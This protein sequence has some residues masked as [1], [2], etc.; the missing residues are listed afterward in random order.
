VATWL[1][2]KGATLRLGLTTFPAG[3]VCEP[4]LAPTVA[5]PA[6]TAN[7]VGTST[8]LQNNASQITL[9]LQA[10][11]PVGGTPTGAA[12]T[13]MSTLTGLTSNDGRADYVV[14]LTDG[15]PNCNANNANSL[16]ACGA[17]CTPAQTSACQCTASICS[18]ALCS[19]GCLDR[20]ATV[21]AVSALAAA[22]VKTI[23]VGFGAD[24]LTTAATPVLDGMARAGGAPRSCPNG[25]DAEC[26]G[27][28][29]VS[30]T[31]APAFYSA[32]NGA[33]LQV[34]LNGLF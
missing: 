32:A 6:P 10:K 23:V 22:G 14:L 3:T 7:D 33:D 34:V 18:G 16:C 27:Q 21:N 17:S 24:T 19:S 30:H 13:L 15:L 11:V 29:C 8:V 28:A 9:Q 31:C 4:P 5:L 26:G 2:A 20:A 1:A 12:L 25:T